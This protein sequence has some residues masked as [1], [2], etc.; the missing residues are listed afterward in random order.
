MGF[1]NT[2]DGEEDASPLGVSAKDPCL[3]GLCVWTPAAGQKGGLAPSS[4]LGC[5]RGR[6]HSQAECAL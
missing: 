4:D 1:S 5:D 2:G 3:N 6:R